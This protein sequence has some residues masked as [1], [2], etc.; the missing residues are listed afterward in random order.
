MTIEQNLKLKEIE[1]RKNC[2]ILERNGNFR[3]A[4]EIGEYGWNKS[5]IFSK[6]EDLIKFAENM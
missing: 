3:I 5:R 2:S 4:W 6:F 1:K